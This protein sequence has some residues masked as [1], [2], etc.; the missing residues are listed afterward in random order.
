MTSGVS[1]CSTH[2]ALMKKSVFQNDAEPPNLMSD[3]IFTNII[4][5]YEVKELID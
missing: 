2:E 1:V 4:N 5:E 3:K